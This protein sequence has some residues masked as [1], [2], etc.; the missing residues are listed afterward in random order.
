MRTWKF[1]KLVKCIRKQGHKMISK[2]LGEFRD[3]EDQNVSIFS[4]GYCFAWISLP[5]QTTKFVPWRTLGS[6]NPGCKVFF[7]FE[8][9]YFMSRISSEFTAVHYHPAAVHNIV[10]STHYIEQETV[11]LRDKCYCPWDHNCSTDERSCWFSFPASILYWR[12]VYWFN[13]MDFISAIE[14]FIICR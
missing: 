11:S 9:H 1:S 6:H 5:A 12:Y 10:L 2:M 4:A 14:P 3:I 8:Y 7:E 13:H